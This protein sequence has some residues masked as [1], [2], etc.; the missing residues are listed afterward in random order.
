VDYASFLKYT[1]ADALSLAYGV[2]RPADVEE[3]HHAGVAIMLGE[4]WQPDFETVKQLDVDIVG[5]GD[6]GAARR[7]LESI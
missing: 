2:V 4:M 3:I 5:W 1:K 7:M 6:P